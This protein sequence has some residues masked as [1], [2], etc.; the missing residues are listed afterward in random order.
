MDLAVG[1]SPSTGPGEGLW[2]GAHGARL[3]QAE[4]HCGPWPRTE[5]PGSVFKDPQP[6]RRG[7]GFLL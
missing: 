5:E 4:G 1:V 7:R 3:Q 2:T 6:A